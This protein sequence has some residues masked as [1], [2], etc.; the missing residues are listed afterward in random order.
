MKWVMR[1]IW[2]VGAFMGAVAVARALFGPF[3]VAGFPV[4]APLNPEGFF[5]LAMTALIAARSAGAAEA[6]AAQ[7]GTAVAAV[8]FL[9]FV[10]QFRVLGLY[11]LSDDFLLIQQARVWSWG[12]LG[13]LLTTAGG[14]GFFRP[15]GYVSMGLNATW[16]G[17]DPWRWHAFSV[18]HHVANAVMVTWLAARLG[19]ST[20]AAFLAG[21]L[22]ALHATHP[23]AS[24]WIAGRFDLL[25]AFFTLAGLLFFLSTKRWAR[26][27]ALGC[28]LLA[29]L[30]K[31]SAFMFPVF[32]VLLQKFRREGLRPVI[33]FA[34][35]TSV[36]FAYRWIL[37]GGIG[38]YLSEETGRAGAFSIGFATTAKAVF[39]RLWTSLYF[40]INWSAEPSFLLAL[41]AAVM[42]AAVLWIAARSR[43]GRIVWLALG[44]LLV[45]IV[46]P[47]HLLGGA[48]DLSGGRLLYL[49]SIWFCLMLAAAAGALP[50]SAQR[51][52]C[53]AALIAFHWVA[54]GHNLSAW[55]S[56]STQVRQTCQNATE[57]I[58]P[59][60]L[61]AD[62]RGVPAFRNGF[63]E[64]RDLARRAR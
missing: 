51:V 11:F 49:P 58:V 3:A 28:C 24:A 4:N 44:A 63:A 18:V 17:E 29:L 7:P 48:A 36:V 20:L 34:V 30:S 47:L 52:A 13:A 62:I 32:L 40:P 27:A 56:A 26:W 33:P 64:C 21:A 14:D 31:E 6:R 9:G 50:S 8:A 22:F 2:T 42:V 55:E 41:L 60:G 39:V 43:P 15:L 37:L 25:A 54:L 59:S 16:A 23:E 19:L 61:P 10:S 57:G 45:S 38:G 1:P 12:N 46:P 35:L 53:A 5:G